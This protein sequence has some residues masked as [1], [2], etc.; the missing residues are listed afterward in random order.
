MV[1]WKNID[2]NG[3][4]SISTLNADG[5]GNITETEYNE[6]LAL[7]RAMPDGKMLVETASGY[8]YADIPEPPDED[9]TPEEAL[10]ILTGVSE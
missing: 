5:E 9:I 2:E 4:V 10:D 6:I 7:L 3:A 1:Y 8:E